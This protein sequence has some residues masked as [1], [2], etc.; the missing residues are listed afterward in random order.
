MVLTK[1]A[2]MQLLLGLLPAAGFTRISPAQHAARSAPFR[3]PQLRQSKR[4]I[5]EV[6]HL[7]EEGNITNCEVVE[8]GRLPLQFGY[9]NAMR[10][11]NDPSMREEEIVFSMPYEDARTGTNETAFTLSNIHRCIEE[12]ICELSDEVLLRALGPDAEEQIAAREEAGNIEEA[13]AAD[14]ATVETKL[15]VHFGAGRLG[16]GLVVPAIAATGVPFA[17]VQRPKKRWQE[18]WM[19]PHELDELDLCINDG[20]VAHRVRVVNSNDMPDFLPPQTL[21]F[22]G[23]DEETKQLA[24]RAT[25][26]SCSLGA[27]MAKVMAPLLKDLPKVPIQEQPVLYCCENDHAAVARLSRTLAGRVRVVDCMVDRVCTGRR[28]TKQGVHVD[29]EPWKGAI[30]VLEP[31]LENVPFSDEI[32]VVPR[33]DREAQYLS[34]R[35]F[36]LVNGMHTVLAF[37]T[38]G[39]NFDPHALGER[40]Y[41]LSKYSRMSP[42]EQRRVEAWR[43][44]RVAKLIAEFGTKNLM[45]WHGAETREEAWDAL[46][47]YSDEVLHERFSKVDDVVSRVLGGGVANRWLTRL[48]PVEEWMKNPAPTTKKRM[49]HD[50]GEIQAFLSYALQ[51]DAAARG[52]TLDEELQDPAACEESVMNEISA[53]VKE[54]K[55]FCKRELAITH[56]SLIQKQ[57]KFGGKMNS[58]LVQAEKKKEQEED[59]AREAAAAAAAA[60]L[61]KPKQPQH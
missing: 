50:Q 60:A 9:D 52:E 3:L 12:D 2:A 8:K 11:L 54:S 31:G 23:A 33:T 37:M 4:D 21:V 44:A 59:A 41:L 19:S 58:P 36:S 48:K 28:I 39:R 14:T 18:L 57:R 38:L 61:S 17:V 7:D 5:F 29:A 45:T 24:G 16:M 49:T 22:G 25:T 1:A 6:C 35:K 34:E 42:D 32:A 15:H 40:E 10:L 53:L 26:L 46:L 51:R 55:Q 13:V 43:A 30:V 20:V 27:A 47:E 56:K